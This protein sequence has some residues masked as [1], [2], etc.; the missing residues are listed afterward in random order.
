MNEQDDLT[1][2][3][4]FEFDESSSRRLRLNTPKTGAHYT[5]QPVPGKIHS[6]LNSTSKRRAV[7][8]MRLLSNSWCFLIPIVLSVVTT[9]TLFHPSYAFL[10]P[11]RSSSL[12]KSP[13]PGSFTASR[14]RRSSPLPRCYA[15]PPQTPAVAKEGIEDLIN[16]LDVINQ[17]LEET[18]HSTLKEVLDTVTHSANDV[19][20]VFKE[21]DNIAVDPSLQTKL[22]D[23]TD[24]VNGAIHDL[25]FVQY[26]VLQP[27]YE[28]IQSQLRT[29]FSDQ[30]LGS[31][32][33]VPTPLA[34]L[35][36]SVVTFTAVSSLLRLGQPPLPVSPYP[37]KRYDADAA[38][39]YF[40]GQFPM[41]LKRGIE[42]ATASLGFGLKLLKDHIK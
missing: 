42:I 38:R 25:V 27:A 12:R 9:C 41:V 39:A 35:L 20:M 34:L 15:L 23:V 4:D 5:H 29:V 31:S 26:P 40:D 16:F 17:R 14:H 21:M 30:L 2:S 13:F 8:R 3:I 37:L 24:A 19:Q 10:L 36:S 1:V 32:S 11:D 18:F 22:H 33:T 28:V 7:T 6:T